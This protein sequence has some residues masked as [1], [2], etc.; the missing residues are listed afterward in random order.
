VRWLFECRACATARRAIADTPTAARHQ[1][2]AEAHPF[3]RPGGGILTELVDE[4]LCGFVGG[5][6]KA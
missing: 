3:V 5:V 4:G 6:I 1:R 2:A